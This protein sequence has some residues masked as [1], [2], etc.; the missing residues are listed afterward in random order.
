MSSK[1]DETTWVGDLARDAR[2][3]PAFASL[4]LFVLTLPIHRLA[5]F[6][7]GASPVLAA[8]LALA[9]TWLAALV[10]VAR[11]KIRPRPDL[12]L[13]AGLAFLAAQALSLVVAHKLGLVPL[14]KLAGFAQMVLLPWLMR[15]VVTTRARFDGIARVWMVAAVG[16]TAVGVL[17]FVTFY[18]AP[19]IGA[20]LMCGWGALAPQKVPRLCA[21][22]NNPNMFL[23]YLTLSCALGIVAWSKALRLSNHARAALPWLAL[24]SFGFVSMFT[25]SAGVGGFGLTGAIAIIAW[26]ERHYSPNRA[27]KWALGGFAGLLTVFAMGTMLATLQPHGYGDIPIGSHDIKVWDGTRPSVWSGNRWRESPITGIGYGELASIVTDARCFIVTEELANAHGPVPTDP[28]LMDGHSVPLNTLAQSGF[29]GLAA[30]L[31]LIVELVRGV[32]W[33]RAELPDPDDRLRRTAVVAMLSGGF[34][35]HGIFG[36]FEEARHIWVAFGLGAAI[37]AHASTWARRTVDEGVAP[38]DR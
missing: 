26:R 5:L 31:L 22:F 19:P 37:A 35:F 36:S 28:K 30:L 23:N 1:P 20:K 7:V 3:E 4:L 27:F 17:G 32:F 2:D 6:H 15:H 11:R 13:Y 16:A 14:V 38:N 33:R 24:V 12:L 34:V 21:P 10:S 25:L 9:L 18:V 8:D 29:V